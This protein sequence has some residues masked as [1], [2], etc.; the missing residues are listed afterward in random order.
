MIRYIGR[1]RNVHASTEI[2][3]W[4]TPV[5]R[6]PVMQRAQVSL[7]GCGDNNLTMINGNPVMP[8]LIRHPVAYHAEDDL[9]SGS[10]PE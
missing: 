7:F 9:D 1:I 2:A 8:D 5:F 6:N 4:H 10:S 3:V